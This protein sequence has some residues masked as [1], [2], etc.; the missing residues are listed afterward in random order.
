MCELVPRGMDINRALQV[1]PDTRVTSLTFHNIRVC[2]VGR[3]LEAMREAGLGIEINV[4]STDLG[5]ALS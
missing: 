5:G 4:E 2:D 3:V 1:P